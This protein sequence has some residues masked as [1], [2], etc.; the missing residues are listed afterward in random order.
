[1]LTLVVVPVAYLLLERAVERVR[2]WRQQPMPRGPADGGARGRRADSARADGRV[3]QR[4]V[5]VRPA[6]AGSPASARRRPAEPAAADDRSR[7]GARETRNERLKVEPGA[8]AR[9]PGRRRRGAGGVPAVAGPE[10]PLHAGAGLA[11]AEDSRRASSARPNRRSART[12][13]RE[14][15]VRFDIS[16]P[17]YTGGRLNH[18]YGAQAATQEGQP[19]RRSS[20]RSRR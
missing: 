11:A 19:A 16:Q 14:N 15:V 10:L 1:M 12:S 2:A 17:L 13:I 7:A 20:A 3:P 18:A 5:G 8:A 6:G 4:R 9:E